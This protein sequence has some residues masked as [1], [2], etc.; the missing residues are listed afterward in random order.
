MTNIETTN[1]L[2]FVK[3]FRIDHPVPIYSDVDVYRGWCGTRRL[4][5]PPGGA[6]VRGGSSLGIGT[7]CFRTVRGSTI[8]AAAFP[9][10]T[11]GKPT[12]Q[13]AP[14]GS[15][16]A[17]PRPLDGLRVYLGVLRIYSPNRRVPGDLLHKACFAR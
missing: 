7:E 8:S 5:L 15:L 2:C 11:S 16:A 1:W 17:L 3:L 13:R 9:I 4:P 14:L 12:V 10:A 6:A